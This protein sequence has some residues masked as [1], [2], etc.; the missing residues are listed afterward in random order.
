[1][2]CYDDNGASP[3]NVFSVTRATGRISV[4]L[5][6]ANPTDVANKTYVDAQDA[7]TL[8]SVSTNYGVL[9][10]GAIIMWPSGT[11]GSTTY[12]IPTGWVQCFGQ[13]YAI[14]S[15]PKLFAA[16][17]GFWFYD[18]TNFG[19]PNLAGRV[20][21]GWDGNATGTGYYVGL[22]GGA[23]TVA[24]AI[25]NMPAHDHGYSQTPHGHTATETPHHHQYVGPG[26]GGAWYYAGAG[27]GV[28]ALSTTYPTSDVAATVTITP[29]VANI[30]FGAQGS[31]VAVENRQPFAVVTFIIRYM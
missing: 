8:A 28:Q 24:L 13:H 21:V 2:S 31:G 26:G 25:S 11:S 23:A 30:T 18:G 4:P 15:M 16:L 27:T 19:V 1:M 9:P 29:Q 7:A 3:I 12:P 6:P 22:L 14:S 17:G 5:T 10:V 20:P